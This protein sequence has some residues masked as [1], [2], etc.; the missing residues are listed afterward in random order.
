MIAKLALLLLAGSGLT[1]Q[2][3]TL[4][5]TLLDGQT[6]SAEITGIADGAVRLAGGEAPLALDA[7][8][9]IG[10]FPKRGPTPIP[11]WSGRLWLRSGAELGC[12]LRA[13]AATDDPASL[14]L[15]GSGL[16]GSPAIPLR[17][18]RG[19]RLLPAHGSADPFAT[20]LAAPPQSEDL[21]FAVQ[22][23]SG[24]LT[25]LSVRVLGL[26]PAGSALLVE[27]G[28]QER[29][30]PIDRVHGLVFG[31]DSGAAP[32]AHPQPR[33]RVRTRRGLELQGRITADTESVQVQHGPGGVRFEFPF[34]AID[35]IQ[36]S[37][38]RVLHL[39]DLDPVVEQ[40][41]AFEVLRPWLR[42]RAPGGDAL[43]L[44][45]RVFSRGLCL[46]PYTRLRFNLPERFDRFEAQVGIDSR[47]GPMGNAT[48]RVLGDD[49]V[50]W[51]EASLVPSGEEISLSLELGSA[52]S[53]TLEVDFGADFDLGDHVVFAEARLVQARDD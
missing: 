2:G 43:M 4:R 45:S 37:S 47:A 38:S 32:E 46:V 36:V 41:P 51:S 35:S 20:A 53:L 14:P 15:I 49:R 12:A 28:G 13:G 3:P 48:V 6:R 19:I 30:V 16:S 11:D 42:N 10:G 29:Q 44:G 26:E 18:I 24:E 40:T 8:Q 34:A 25:R 1:A 22:P 17:L 31:R 9:S 5:L 52:R 7:L 39:G 33:V 50:L 27:F 21:L 23:G